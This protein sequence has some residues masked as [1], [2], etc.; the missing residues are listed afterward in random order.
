M[1]ER[2]LI[3]GFLAEL[4]FCRGGPTLR[5][6]GKHAAINRRTAARESSPFGVREFIPA[7]CLLFLH[8]SAIHLSA[9]HLSV[10]NGCHAAT[11]LAHPM[12]DSCPNLPEIDFHA[13]FFG[14]FPPPLGQ[15]D[16][17]MDV[18]RSHQAGDKRRKNRVFRFFGG[19]V[20]SKRMEGQNSALIG[21]WRDTKCGLCARIRRKRPFTCRP[22]IFLLSM[23]LSVVCAIIVHPIRGNHAA[24]FLIPVIIHKYLFLS[25]GAGRF[26]FEGQ[27]AP[28]AV[29]RQ[30][31]LREYTRDR[32]MGRKEVEECCRFQ[33]CRIFFPFFSP[34]VY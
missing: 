34:P 3:D 18:Y 30:K 27:V 33:P 31:N 26:F 13:R 10:H 9:R 32:K 21:L 1:L 24:L 14:H 19:E 8:L 5:L 28:I 2:V 23:F 4:G 25:R 11:S 20:H 16:L 7:L 6:N 17:L 15:Y 12:G 29:V 22:F